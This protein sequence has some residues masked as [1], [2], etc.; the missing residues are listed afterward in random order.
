MFR[1]HK[2]YML[3]VQQFFRN[4]FIGRQKFLTMYN[5]HAVL[6]A[7]RR[8]EEKKEREGEG[9]EEE[10][11]EGKERGKRRKRKGRRGKKGGGGVRT[12]ACIVP[13][14]NLLWQIKLYQVHVHDDCDKVTSVRPNEFVCNFKIL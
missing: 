1:K 8:R 13:V 5:V 9:G 10:G 11:G 14:E 7:V 6:T 4:M 12:R 3:N 2:L